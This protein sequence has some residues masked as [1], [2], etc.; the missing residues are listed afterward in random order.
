LRLGKT[1]TQATFSV[2]DT[3]GADTMDV[4]I[5]DANGNEIDSTVTGDEFHWVP[6]GALYLPT[7]KESP[8]SVTITEGDFDGKDHPHLPALVWIAVSDSG[9]AHAPGFS[10]YHLDVDIS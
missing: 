4:F 1:T 5:F 2:Y 8:A 7:S 3:K 10:T 9:P 6:N